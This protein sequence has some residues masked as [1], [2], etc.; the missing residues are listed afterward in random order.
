MQ[1][2]I[3]LMFELWNSR[4]DGFNLAQSINLNV[5]NQLH[6]KYKNKAE[7]GKT[8]SDNIHSHRMS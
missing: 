5:Y 1:D 3:L 4:S 8:G 6:Q 2:F 7:T